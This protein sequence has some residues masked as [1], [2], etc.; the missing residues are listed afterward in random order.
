MLKSITIT[1]T[2]KKVSA[3]SI[4]VFVCVFIK[5]QDNGVLIF[6]REVKQQTNGKIMLYCL[7]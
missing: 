3:K 2:E 5:K 1:A 7:K 4:Y 6:N